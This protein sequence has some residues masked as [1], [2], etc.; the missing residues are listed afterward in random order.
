MNHDEQRDAERVWKL[1]TERIA[2]HPY[3]NPAKVRRRVVVM[4][5]TLACTLSLIGVAHGTAWWPFS[6]D[7][8]PAA[9]Q[10]AAFKDDALAPAA[11]AA[12]EVFDRTSSVG[13]DLERSLDRAGVQRSPH[14]LVTD[15]SVQVVGAA[16]GS[17]ACFAVQQRGR[18]N[19]VT[20]ST[21]LHEIGVAYSLDI[22]VGD[23]TDGFVLAG[24]AAD[25]V[26]NIT[27]L[28]DND[29]AESARLAN[30]GFVWRGS[31]QPRALRVQVGETHSTI[32]LPRS[33][34]LITAPD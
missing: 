11:P 15:D 14:V 26:Q 29:T 27:V 8:Q 20:C 10:I 25:E 5:A 34:S 3:R 7:E 6:F 2:A 12:A 32:E 19:G 28:L 4:A 24:V 9:D 16:R 31:E 1:V 18:V 33:S 17:S 21:K 13:R 30:N 23:P 22:N